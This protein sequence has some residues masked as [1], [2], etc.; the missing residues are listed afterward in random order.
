MEPLSRKS[1]WQI[2][3][4]HATEAGLDYVKTH[5]LRRFVGT[6][7]AKNDLRKAQKVLRHK[8]IETTTYVLDDIEVGITDG[9][10]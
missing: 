10:Y 6:Q 5:D 1:L 2:V 7:L 3:K 8:R 4:A 9:L